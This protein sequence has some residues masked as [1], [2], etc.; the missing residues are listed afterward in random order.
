MQ[1][2]PATLIILS[3]LLVSLLVGGFILTRSQPVKAATN[4]PAIY[5]SP[6]QA[7]CYIAAPN[8]CRIHVDP[9]TIDIAPGQKLVDYKLVTFQMPGGPIILIH[10][11]RTDQSNPPPYIGST[12]SPSLVAQDYGAT[13]GKSYQLVLEGSDSGD[14]GDYSLGSTKTFTCPSTIP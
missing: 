10:D 12:Y 4:A 6:I 7:G 2:K 14:T 3:F 13:C 9:F 8:D 5:A 11:F 1:K